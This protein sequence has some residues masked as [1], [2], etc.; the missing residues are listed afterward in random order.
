MAHILRPNR[1]HF[2]NRKTEVP[3]KVTGNRERLRQ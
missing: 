1:H 3:P 2:T